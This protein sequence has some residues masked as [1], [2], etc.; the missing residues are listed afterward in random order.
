MTAFAAAARALFRD[1][2]MTVP[3]LYRVGGDPMTVGVAVR[4]IVSAP[5]ALVEFGG[6]RLKSDTSVI[7]VPSADVAAVA[8]GDTFEIEAVTYIVVAE[9]MRDVEQLSWRCEVRPA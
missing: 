7:E 5:D 3:A 6:A 1:R 2:N 9:P 4:V 8:K